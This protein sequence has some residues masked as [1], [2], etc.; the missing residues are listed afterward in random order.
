VVPLAQVGAA[1]G[2]FRDTTGAGGPV[3]SDFPGYLFPFGYP[4]NGTGTRKI[5]NVLKSVQLDRLMTNI[6]INV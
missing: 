6:Q 1:G 2:V 5:C 3:V 4:G